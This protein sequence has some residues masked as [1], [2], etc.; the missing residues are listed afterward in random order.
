M[1][2]RDLYLAAYGVGSLLIARTIYPRVPP[3]DTKT[4]AD[5]ITCSSMA[6]PAE[7]DQPRNTASYSPA[8]TRHSQLQVSAIESSETTNRYLPGRAH[9][10]STYP[11]RL[12]NPRLLRAVAV[13]KLWR[14]TFQRLIGLNAGTVSNQRPGCEIANRKHSRTAAHSITA[15]RGG[16]P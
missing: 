10:H 4:R 16:C 13:R 9:G 8:G 12:P 11:R 15:N 3:D 14:P 7:C 6:R 2:D 5:I 1:P